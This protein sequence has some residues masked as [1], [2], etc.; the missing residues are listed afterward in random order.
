M[1]QEKELEVWHNASLATVGVVRHDGNGNRI[2]E[3]IVGGRKLHISPVERRINE[4]IAADD[5]L[6]PFKNGMLV[7]VRLLDSEPDSKEL[8]A[9]S[10][11]MSETAMKALFRSQLPT[12][13]KKVGEISNPITLGRLLEVASEVDGSIKQVEA[14][15][16]RL[17][18]VTPKVAEVS[19]QRI[20]GSAAIGTAAPKGDVRIPRGVTPR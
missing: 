5:T 16:A 20:A 18:D 17:A 7:P 2:H 15:Q 4:E 12:F 14:I 10:N 13:T 19:A 6:N 11:A 3:S 8:Q 1:A 9:N